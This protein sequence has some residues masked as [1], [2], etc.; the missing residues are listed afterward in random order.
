VDDVDLRAARLGLLATVRDAGGA[1]LDW[2]QLR[3]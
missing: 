2:A 3:M 1:V